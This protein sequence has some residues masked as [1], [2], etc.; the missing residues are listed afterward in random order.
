MYS[1][2]QSVYRHLNKHF[3]FS[4]HLQLSELHSASENQAIYLGVYI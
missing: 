2:A 1:E 3:D 4:E